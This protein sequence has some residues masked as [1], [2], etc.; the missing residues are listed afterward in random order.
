MKRRWTM[1]AVLSLC[2]LLFFG[3]SAFAFD[4]LSGIP[5]SSKIESLK[6]DRIVSGDSEKEFKP[7]RKTT[8]AEG[9]QLIVKGLDL[10][11][12]NIKFIKKPE[13][14][15]YFTK[16]PDDAWYAQAF[17]IAQHNG[18]DLPRNIDPKSAM[19]RQDFAMYLARAITYKWTFMQTMQFIVFADSDEVSKEASSAVQMLLKAHIAEL[20]KENRFRPADRITRAEAAVMIYNARLF[21]KD[22]ELRDHSGDPSQPPVQNEKV[23][24]QI[25][26]VNSSV[27]E[28]T[29]VWGEKPNPGYRITIDRIQ[30]TDDRKAIVYYQLHYPQPGDSYAQV[31]T[32]AK[33]VTYVD[34]GY[35]VSAQ[36][37]E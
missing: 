33:A 15:D 7:H 12:D 25:K 30:F 2:M 16:V 6:N 14:S 23:D 28:V 11:I 10:N 21:V 36:R 32:D 22:K 3:T 1:L 5:G 24:V 17:I 20:D 19:S 35:Q 18:M 26:A 37:M 8:Y 13:A 34:A 27:N 31:V 29:L 9:I 4:D